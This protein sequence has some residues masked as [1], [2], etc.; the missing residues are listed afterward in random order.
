MLDAPQLSVVAFR[1]R[2]DAAEADRLGPELLRR[3]NARRRVF[4]S[5]TRIGGRYALRI[6]VLSYRTHADRVRDA[7]EA[8]REEARALL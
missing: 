1:L 2:A 4:L 5:S 7:V 3:V 8:L 6:C